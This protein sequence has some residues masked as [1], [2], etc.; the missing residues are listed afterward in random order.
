MQQ[1]LSTFAS[2]GIFSTGNA[3]QG[4]IGSGIAAAV[5]NG[6]YVFHGPY[7]V[8]YQVSQ[9]TSH[10][11]F[12]MTS[13]KQSGG[14]V[15]NYSDRFSIPELTGTTALNIKNAV[16]TL[17]GDTQG[18]PS[19]GN[20]APPTSSSTTISSSVPSSTA[21]AS[22]TLQPSSSPTQDP[23]DDLPLDPTSPDHDPFPLSPGAKAGFAI[24]II[25]GVALLAA[26]GSIFYFRRRRRQNE[27]QRTV[28]GPPYSP[29]NASEL[30]AETLV[31]PKAAWTH[32]SELSSESMVH[33]AGEGERRPELE[34]GVFRAELEGCSPVREKM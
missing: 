18:P 25:A 34:G 10:S 27:A 2:Q 32:H 15:I 4:S 11:F 31:R 9:L 12:R 30:S 28:A 23:P 21:T 16:Q 13:T 20:N 17:K 14:V 8:F 6:L 7:T 1:P 3:A 33:E 22:P 29:S 24:G 19:V 5:E 26:L